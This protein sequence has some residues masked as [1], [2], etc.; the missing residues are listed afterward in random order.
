MSVIDCTNAMVYQEIEIKSLTFT[1]NE[2]QQNIITEIN[3]APVLTDSLNILRLELG[4]LA[5]VRFLV[6][7][8]GQTSVEPDIF[9]AII[10]LASAMVFERCVISN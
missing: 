10:V 3:V 2:F 7:I 1:Q 9:C 5:Y 4:R 6:L 8:L